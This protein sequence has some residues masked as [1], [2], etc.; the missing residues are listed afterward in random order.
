M[1]SN[2]REVKVVLRAPGNERAWMVEVNQEAAVDNLLPDLVEA[3]P[4]EGTP[5]DY[6]LRWVGSLASPYLVIEPRRGR[7]VG[8]IRDAPN[9]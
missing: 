2:L 5:E 6:T 9:G 1:A 3:L 4:I 7:N 8:R